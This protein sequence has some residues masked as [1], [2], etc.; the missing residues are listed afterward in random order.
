MQAR[1]MH[2]LEHTRR[3]AWVAYAGPQTQSGHIQAHSH[4]VTCAKQTRSRDRASEGSLPAI[5]RS[6]A[7]LDLPPTALKFRNL[8][9]R[10]SSSKSVS[11]TCRKC[12][13]YVQTEHSASNACKKTCD[14]EIKTACRQYQIRA[15][16]K[17]LVEELC[18]ALAYFQS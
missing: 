16:A 4:G 18:A 15:A 1:F 10:A 7:A 12:A 11:H 14:L 3:D 17:S 5:G 2:T 8:S 9:C 6:S 13:I